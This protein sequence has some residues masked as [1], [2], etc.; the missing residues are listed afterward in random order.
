MGLIQEF[1]AFAMRGNVVD[2]AV[3]IIIG[4]A[5]GKIVSSIVSDI[6][7]PPI[8]LL[9]GGVN[10]TDLKLTLKAAQLD[11]VTGKTVEAVTL[12][13]GKFLQ[14][15]VDF[16]ILAF[17]IFLMVKAM[18]TLKKKEEVKPSAPPVPTKEELLLTD[19]RDILKAQK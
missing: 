16:I 3:G 15:T 9:M 14:T 4:G 11:A 19:I 8:G 10:F 7:M 18:N 6:I 2:M 13:Y 5:F 17:A 1:K 12:N